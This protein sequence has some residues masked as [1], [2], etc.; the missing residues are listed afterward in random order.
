MRGGGGRGLGTSVLRGGARIAR[1]DR[2]AALGG[3]R[4]PSLRGRLVRRQRRAHERR[5]RC[6]VR[7]S[8]RSLD[9]TRP[10]LRT[11]KTM[12]SSQRTRLRGW[13]AAARR[14]TATRCAEAA[15]SD[16]WLVAMMGRGTRIGMTAVTVMKAREC[17]R[18]LPRHRMEC[19]ERH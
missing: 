7:A 5:S 11:R 10:P 12:S 8:L 4:L 13:R 15:D 17:V 14:M 9:F 2:A 1:R 19:S 16:H 6:V 3:G 18:W